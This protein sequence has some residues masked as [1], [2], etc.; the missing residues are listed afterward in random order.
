[1]KIKLSAFA[2]IRTLGNLVCQ[3]I[4]RQVIR[5]LQELNDKD[6][7]LSGDNSGLVNIWDEICVQMQF[8]ESYFWDVYEEM[9]ESSTKYFVEKLPNHE[10]DAAWLM[11]SEGES[12]DCEP[13]DDRDPDPVFHDDIVKHITGCVLTIGN[14]WSNHRI[15]SY[16]DGHFLDRD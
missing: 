9:I 15:R 3:R 4:S 16:I 10:R 12:W 8:E 14:D 11:T 5:N 13:E 2:I 1:M 6:S 7:L